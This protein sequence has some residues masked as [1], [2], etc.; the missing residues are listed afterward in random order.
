MSTSKIVCP[1]CRQKIFND[2][3]LCKKCLATLKEQVK[4]GNFSSD[5]EKAELTALL[6]KNMGR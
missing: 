1:E 4:I 2:K 5:Q 3:P 6:K